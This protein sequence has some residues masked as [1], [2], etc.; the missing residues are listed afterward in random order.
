MT[1]QRTKYPVIHNFAVRLDNIQVRKNLF[2][3]TKKELCIKIYGFS[4]R[5]LD[6]QK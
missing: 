3:L 6:K 1:H 2:C 5:D 4:G